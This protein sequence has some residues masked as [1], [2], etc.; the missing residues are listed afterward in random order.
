MGDFTPRTPT[1]NPLYTVAPKT[2]FGILPVE[3]FHGSPCYPRHQVFKYF[4]S[5]V[6][7]LTLPCPPE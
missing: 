3:S 4:L 5:G 7:F 6:F 2:N 1:I